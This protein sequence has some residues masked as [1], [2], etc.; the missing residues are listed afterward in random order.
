VRFNHH[1]NLFS[2]RSRLAAVSSGDYKLVVETNEL[3]W[4]GIVT[5]WSRFLAVE[6]YTRKR[7]TLDQDI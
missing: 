4:T 3:T 5:G 7:H 1:L 2:A 6:G